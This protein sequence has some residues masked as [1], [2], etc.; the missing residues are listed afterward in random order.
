[1]IEDIRLA[2][3]GKTKVAHYGRMGGIVPTP[4]EVVEA[5]KQNIINQTN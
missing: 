1:M 3:N 5:L 2:V 4:E